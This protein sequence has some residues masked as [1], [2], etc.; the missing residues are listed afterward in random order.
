MDLCENKCNCQNIRHDIFRVR[1]NPFRKIG[2]LIP[3]TKQMNSVRS[4][5]TQ[6]YPWINI[7]LKIEYKR[8]GALKASKPWAD[9]RES[10]LWNP[11]H[12][13]PSWT[14][15]TLSSWYYDVWIITV[16]KKLKFIYKYV[17]NEFKLWNDCYKIMYGRLA[18]CTAAQ[19]RPAPR[20]LWSTE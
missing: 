5:N 1:V 18:R 10:C 9:D 3:F 12:V 8:S 6:I 11:K 17:R 16:N 7:E 20:P 14:M 19:Q 15:I 4:C 13:L 2:K